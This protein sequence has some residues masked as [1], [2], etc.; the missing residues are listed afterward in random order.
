MYPENPKDP[1]NRRLNE[2]GIYI[3]HCQESNSQLVPSQAGV[4]TTRP[5]WRTMMLLLRLLPLLLLHLRL[6]PAAT[7]AAA[8][9]AAAAVASAVAAAAAAAAAAATT[10]PAMPLS[11]PI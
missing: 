6:T 10:A 3:R 4:D 2:H 11:C 7:A 9:D 5:Q 8:P 1:S